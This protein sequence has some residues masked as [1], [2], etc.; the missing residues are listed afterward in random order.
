MYTIFLIGLQYPKVIPKPGRYQIKSEKSKQF[1][2]LSFNTFNW[3]IA[4][5]LVQH[6]KIKGATTLQ[7]TIKL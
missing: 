6:Q 1:H 3:K 7:Q 4:V 5:L 2:N